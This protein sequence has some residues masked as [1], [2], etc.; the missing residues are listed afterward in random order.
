MAL[1]LTFEHH[2]LARPSL[3]GN[4][5]TKMKKK[6]ALK[7]E[8]K[9]TSR[10][11]F[12]FI[13]LRVLYPFVSQKMLKLILAGKKLTAQAFQAKENLLRQDK[14]QCLREANL[15]KQKLTTSLLQT[16]VEGQWRY[17]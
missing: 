17:G 4:E 1:D 14:Y 11:N 10:S 2:L 9:A 7:N 8:K 6:A 13:F 3:A 16:I 5:R 15:K 12:N